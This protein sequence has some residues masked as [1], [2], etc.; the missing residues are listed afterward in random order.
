VNDRV[1]N[2]TKNNSIPFPYVVRWTLIFAAGCVAHFPELALN[3][4]FVN[5]LALSERQ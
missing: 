5:P 1:R 2:E 3:I 4:G